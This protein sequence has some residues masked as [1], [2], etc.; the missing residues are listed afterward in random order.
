MDT[1]ALSKPTK[2]ETVFMHSYK[3]LTT[4]IS[5]SGISFR[6]INPSNV[7]RYGVKMF[8]KEMS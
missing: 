8:V 3:E 7:S 6:T 2:V 4:P 5:V 1:Q